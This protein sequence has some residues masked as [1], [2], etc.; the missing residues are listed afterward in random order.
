MQMVAVAILYLKR[1][2]GQPS[3][4][5][6]GSLLAVLLTV[7]SAESQ[8]PDISNRY[9][10]KI[11][12]GA[13][14]KK[15]DVF[16]KSKLD[17]FNRGRSGNST[18]RNELRNK[19]TLENFNAYSGTLSQ[20]LAGELRSNADVEFI[21]AEQIFTISGVQANPPSW[22][23]P[24]ISERALDTSAP[25]NYPDPAGQGVDV[26][27]IDTGINVS[28][29]EFGGRATLPISFIS[30]ESTADLHGHGTHISGTIGGATYGVAKKVNQAVRV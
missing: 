30:G 19:F 15:V 29:N 14:L 21:E 2:P 9:I 3:Y 6:L 7:S 17:Q 10:V 1:K 8:H 25:Y 11:K 23:L 27:I 28:H 24:R 4:F 18:L 5:P 12:N 16:L 20:T 22:D 13:D 26:Y